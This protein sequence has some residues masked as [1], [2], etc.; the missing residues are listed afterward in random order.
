MP[1]QYNIRFAAEHPLSMGFNIPSGRDVNAAMERAIMA[2]GLTPVAS[3]CH[4]NDDQGEMQY[5]SINWYLPDVILLAAAK[6]FEAQLAQ[7]MDPESDKWDP[8][9]CTGEPWVEIVDLAKDIIARRAMGEEVR[10]S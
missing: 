7:K 1:T 6:L 4:R 10:T 8:A 5:E 2:L 9:F 3:E